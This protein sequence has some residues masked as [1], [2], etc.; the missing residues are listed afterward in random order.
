M[1]NSIKKFSMLACVSLLGLSLAGCAGQGGQSSDN[2]SSAPSASKSSAA[3]DSNI[4]AVDYTKAS[5]DELKDGGTL[6]LPIT[7]IPEQGNVHH[8]DASAYARVLWE[9]YNP[10]VV[11]FDDDFNPVPNPDYVTNVKEEEKDGKTIVTYTINE[12]ASFNDGTPIDWK[13]FEA[14][15]KIN[16]GQ[17]QD[18]APNSTDGYQD[19]VSV[20]AGENDKQAVVTFDKIYVW[21]YGLFN[22]LAHPKLVDPEFYKSGYLKT[23]NNDLG[24]GPFIVENYDANAGRVSFVRNDKWWGKP[25]KLD[26]ITY[27]QM[28]ATAQLNALKNGEID[29]IDNKS[30]G[31]VT[32]KERFDAVKDIP[33]MKVYTAADNSSSVF[34]LNSKSEVLSD[35]RVRKALFQVR[36]RDQLA[37]IS[38][39]GLDYDAPRAGSFVLFNNQEGYED[40]FSK[41]VEFDPEGAK[42]LL[43]EA[44]WVPGDDGIRVKDGKR[45]ELDWPLFGDS[46]TIKA[47]YLAYQQMCKDA[48]IQI[49][50]VEYPSKE[51]SNVYTKRQFDIMSLGF[52]SSDPFGVAYFNQI[53]GS[54]SGLNLSSTGTEEFDKKIEE[55]AKIPNAKD[56]IAAANKLEV[57]AFKLYGI[58]PG[59]V[60]PARTIMKE[61]L[62]NMGSRGLSTT[63]PENIGWLK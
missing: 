34:M 21:Y 27:V 1:K 16:N 56:Q 12:K 58:M 62:A 60:A 22:N 30:A 20:T 24:A 15:W 10:V 59:S 61:G 43:D 47:G 9:L 44:G 50:I 32:T 36:D 14:T 54:D 45:L 3:L 18:Y 7:E 52:R 38:F 28:E 42:K 13:T 2:A 6:T 11:T 23:F 8:Q 49:N 25:A 33:G 5:Y 48:G 35:P 51:F 29:G 41:A 39:N 63:T 40:N 4:K 57:E 53:Y 37:K 55:L 26:K 31:G 19:I 17:T 46:Q